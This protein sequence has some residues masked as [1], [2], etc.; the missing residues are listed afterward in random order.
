MYISYRYVLSLSIKRGVDVDAVLLP[1]NNKS[2][3]CHQNIPLYD[4]ALMKIVYT[5]TK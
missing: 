1:P 3:I 5:R 4:K 2:C